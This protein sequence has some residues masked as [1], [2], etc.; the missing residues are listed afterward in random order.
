MRQSISSKR[1]YHHLVPILYHSNMLSPEEK[2]VIPRTTR[3]RWDK[4]SHHDYFGYDMVKDYIDDFDY[5]KD[6]LTNKHI[7]QGV[8][9]MSALSYGYKDVIGEIEGSKK[10]M[11]EHADKITFGIQR[12]ARMGNIK[13]TDA[14]KIFG[15]NR[16]WFYRHRNKKYCSK[17]KIDKCYRQYP[18]QLAY[19]EVERIE[20]IVI[21]PENRIKTKTSLYYHAIR[22]GMVACALSTFFK[23][24][25]LVGYRK[26]K[27][28]EAENRKKGF[29]ASKPFEWL[30]VDVTHIQTQKD[31]IQYVAFIKDNFSKALLGYSSTSKRPDSGFIRD[32]FEA[33]FYKYDLMNHSEGIN[34]LSDGGSENKGLFQDWVNQIEAPS[35]VRKLTAKTP[36]FPFSNNMSE[37]THSIYKTE[38]MR[39]GYSPDVNQHM[40]D[41]ARFMTYYNLER[42]PTEH[43]G[44]RPS[45]VLHGEKPDRNRFKEQIQK[46]KEERIITNRLFN[47]C[48]FVCLPK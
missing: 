10:L 3:Q 8:K 18:N 33:T 2:A 13:L 38:F 4:F 39:G 6:V 11:R 35:I 1:S 23:Y 9:F 17:S 15:V 32:L 29:R 37:S 16:D 40:N 12:L 22:N 27:K 26:Y 21:A 19:E 30:H 47:D 44:L 25:D 28:P 5:I 14:C 45:E 20:K 46:G 48:P 31:G 42:Y 36:E 41:L 34:L 7:K 24:A 43:F